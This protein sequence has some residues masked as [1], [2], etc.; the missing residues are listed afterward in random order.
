MP[1]FVLVHSHK[2]ADCRFAFAAWRGHDSPLSHQPALGG[3]RQGH[4]ELWWIVTTADEGAALQLLPS[5]VAQRTRAVE[6]TEL[7]IP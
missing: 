1:T 4:H 7:P 5:F 3:C 6:V 2:P